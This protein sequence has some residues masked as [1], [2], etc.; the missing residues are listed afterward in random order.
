MSTQYSSCITLWAELLSGR[1]SLMM[2]AYTCLGYLMCMCVYISTRVITIYGPFSVSPLGF[3]RVWVCV[4]TCA[5]CMCVPDC[6]HWVC[7]AR[8]L[9]P[10]G[11]VADVTAWHKGDTRAGGS[12]PTLSA[13]THTQ[14]YPPWP[15]AAVGFLDIRPPVG[16]AAPWV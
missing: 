5:A 3:V 10:C 9:W 15:G 7:F 4:L 14:T 2:L 6:C 11:R 12:Q 16:G 1:N 13:H 8:D